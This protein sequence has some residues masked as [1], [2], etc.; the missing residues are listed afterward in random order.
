MELDRA[1]SMLAKIVNKPDD[2]VAAIYSNCGTR[3]SGW[4]VLS[5]GY[6]G[7]IE[8]EQ[9]LQ[10]IWFDG[11]LCGLNEGGQHVKQAIMHAIN[12]IMLATFQI[13]PDDPDRPRY[14]A[15]PFNANNLPFI[16]LEDDLVQRGIVELETRS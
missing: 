3:V 13:E 10:L 15:P 2:L 7:G 5:G 9:A 6:G 14:R 4:G 12:T 11:F 16:N 1:R 8:Q